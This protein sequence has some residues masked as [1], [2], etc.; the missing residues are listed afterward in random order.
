MR[1]LVFAAH[2]DDELIGVGGTI[3][4]LHEK[5][6]NVRVII[7]SRGGGGVAAEEPIRDE[8]GIEQTRDLETQQVAKYLGFKHITLGISEIVDRREAVKVA[9]KIIREFKPHIVFTHSP[10]DHHHLH[11]AVS[12]VST[13]A[14]WQAAAKTYGYLGKPWRVSSV[15]YYEVWDLFTRPNL[16]VDISDTFYKKLEAMKLYKSQLKVFPGITDYLE[17]LARVRGYLIGVKYAEAFKLS[18]ILPNILSEHFKS[19]IDLDD[20]LL[21]G[22]L[23]THK[24]GP[25]SR[26]F[27]SFI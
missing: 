2:P 10:Y 21:N 26:K 15:Y 14:C 16:V 25:F 18:D 6:A 24:G 9:V 3:A 20:P 23:E 5:G 11:I 7:Y 13:E 27:E 22:F 1:V 4:K 8:H 12:A 19:P 17:S